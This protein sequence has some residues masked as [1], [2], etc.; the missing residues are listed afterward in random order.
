MTNIKYYDKNSSGLSI[1]D[2]FLFALTKTIFGGKMKFIIKPLFILLI[3]SFMF[4]IG[5]GDSP[6]NDTDTKKPSYGKVSFDFGLNTASTKSKQTVTETLEMLNYRKSILTTCGVYI[7]NENGEQVFSHVYTLPLEEDIVTELP[8]GY[9]FAQVHL[10]SKFG[11]TEF[12]DLNIEFYCEPNENSVV[13]VNLED[14]SYSFLPVQVI[15]PIGDYEEGKSFPIEVTRPDY[16][17]RLHSES[18]ALYKDGALHFKL[19]FNYTFP[20]EYF[21]LEVNGDKMYCPVNI[22]DII[23]FDYIP[24]TAKPLQ[25]ISMEV[26]F[27]F[28]KDL[29]TGFSDTIE[30]YNYKN[31]YLNA[32]QNHYYWVEVKCETPESIIT[33]LYD[34]DYAIINASYNDTK[35]IFLA[36][37]LVYSFRLYAEQVASFS[38]K[39]TDL[40][41]EPY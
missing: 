35:F 37:N 9:Y 3:A 11:S 13:K 31:Y 32:E 29:L 8:E 26:E 17:G 2:K 18:T 30:K 4:C 16:S 7:E 39:V 25:E 20:I 12:C 34:N 24:S 22:M 15:K 33:W 19:Y 10:G 28:E 36:T 27:D 41:S 14:R 40:G 21:Y 5:C 1:G 6:S 23:K 38:I